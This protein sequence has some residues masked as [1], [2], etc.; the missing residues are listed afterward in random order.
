[1][2]KDIINNLTLVNPPKW[3]KEYY[4]KMLQDYLNFTLQKEGLE[5]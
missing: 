2:T 1:M 4:N 5:K 3:W